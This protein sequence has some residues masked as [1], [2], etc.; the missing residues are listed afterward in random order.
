MATQHTVTQL[1]PTAFENYGYWARE[2]G[3]HTVTVGYK[4]KDNP[5]GTFII[6]ESTFEAV[7]NAIIEHF[8]KT[9]VDTAST[10]KEK[11]E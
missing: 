6:N 9:A 10:L 2:E 8:I 4:D 5:I 11:T 7:L 1:V 3:D